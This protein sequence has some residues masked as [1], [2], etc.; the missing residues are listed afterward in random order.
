MSNYSVWLLSFADGKGYVL[1]T[2]FDTPDCSKWNTWKYHHP[3]LYQAVLNAG[4]MENVRKTLLAS[5]ESKEAAK[6][7]KKAF[8]HYLGTCAPNGYNRHIGGNNTNRP[9]RYK[10]VE[11]LNEAGDVLAWFS[12]GQA[13]SA[14]TGI[15]KS[16]ISQAVHGILKTSG[17]YHWRKA[18]NTTAAG[19]PAA[20]L[21]ESEGERA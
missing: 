14:V 6:A 1:T 20:F 9:Y 15:S 19:K 21:I 13:A 11:M 16:G 3:E 4:G 18:D 17:G 10:P 5:V 2:H 7:V 12:S 8:I